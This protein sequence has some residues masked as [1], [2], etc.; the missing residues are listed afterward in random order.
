MSDKLHFLVTAPDSPLSLCN[1]V[2]TKSVD[3]WKSCSFGTLV[4]PL[5]KAEY[6]REACALSAT[7]L[8]KAQMTRRIHSTL[9]AERTL[10]PMK[11]STVTKE[12]CERREHSV[13]DL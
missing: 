11:N 1:S 13:I 8:F 6:C 5:N 12:L 3:Q 9:Y 2:A 7:S 10:V 4:V